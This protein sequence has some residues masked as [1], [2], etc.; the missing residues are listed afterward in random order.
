[1][2]CVVHKGICLAVT[3]TRRAAEELRG[4]LAA[5]LPP[6][7]GACAVHSFHSLGLAILRANG[8]AGG[9]KPDF[10]IADEPERRAAL[11]AALDVTDSKA[12]RLL[13]AISLL[14]R[15]GLKPDDA[16]TGSEFYR[17]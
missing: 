13:K 14:K 4:R 15:T 16:E 12:G 9:L 8:A 17:M 1:L 5:L 6:G 2:S 7:L 3:F 10:R 11:A